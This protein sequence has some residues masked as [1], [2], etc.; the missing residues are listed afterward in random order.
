MGTIAFMGRRSSR[1]PALCSRRIRTLAATLALAG[2]AAA[3]PQAFAPSDIWD[4]REIVDVRINPEGDRVVYAVRQADRASNSWQSRLWL[5]APG[6]TAPQSLSA[7][8]AR[9]THPR[10]SPDGS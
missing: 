2:A 1:I 5:A 6:G 9:D 8:G 3:Q 7:E 10:W 4:L